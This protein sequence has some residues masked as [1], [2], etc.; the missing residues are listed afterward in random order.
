MNDPIDDSNPTEEPGD[1]PLDDLLD[2][3]EALEGGNDPSFFYPESTYADGRRLDNESLIIADR[4]R[5][6]CDLYAAGKTMREVAEELKISVSTVHAHLHAVHENL[7]R[8]AQSKLADRIARELLKLDADERDVRAEWV[9]SK[10]EHI[11]SSTSK[12]DGKTPGSTASVKKRTKFGDAKLGAL[13]LKI[14]DQ[15]CKLLG[16][17]EAAEKQKV[18][19]NPPVKLVSGPDPMDLV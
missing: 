4:R 14:R 7:K 19:P 15:R 11:E 6:V 3:A 9:R 8:S 12:R 17:Y 5:K 16:L 18:Q 10:G 13:L 1:E 2:E